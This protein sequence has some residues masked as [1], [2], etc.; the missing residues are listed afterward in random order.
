MKTTVE[1]P[2]ALLREARRYGR[3]HDLTFRQV[4]ERSLRDLL[5]KENGSRKPFRLKRCSFR[6]D[7]VVGEYSWPEIRADIYEGR[8]E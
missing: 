2:D 8:G 7:D 3:D 4:L 5:G 1:I 6:G